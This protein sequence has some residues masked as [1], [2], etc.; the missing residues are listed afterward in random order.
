MQ[1]LLPLVSCLVFVVGCGQSYEEALRVYNDEVAALEVLEK[2]QAKLKQMEMD[3]TKETFAQYHATYDQLED[4]G[5]SKGDFMEMELEDLKDI[6]SQF[7][8][9]LKKTDK[10]IVAQKKRIQEAKLICDKLK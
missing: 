4:I 10:M 9:S 3:F 7:K 8:P 5:A 2:H 6:E 1:R